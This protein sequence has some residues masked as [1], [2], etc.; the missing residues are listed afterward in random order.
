MLFGHFVEIDIARN[1]LICFFG[2]Q[3][4]SFEAILI[5][6]GGTNMLLPAQ[7][8]ICGDMNT[9]LSNTITLLGAAPK[10]FVFF[11]GRRYRHF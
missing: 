11:L 9:L 8:R 7:A 3:N 4:G 2:S 10:A 5:E 6:T 1:L